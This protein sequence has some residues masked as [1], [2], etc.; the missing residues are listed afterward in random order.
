MPLTPRS[1]LKYVDATFVIQKEEHKHNILE[2]I[3]SVDPAIKFTV[4]DTMEDGAIPFI[5]TIVKPETDNTLS[6]T[7]YR[8][9]THTDQ[10]LQWDSHHHL[11]AKYS[12]INTLNPQGKNNMQQAGASPEGNG[13]P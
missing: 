8:M 12:F 11:L 6:I 5:D 7:M 9:P 10:Y 4:E 1:W 13:P 3:Y 2:H